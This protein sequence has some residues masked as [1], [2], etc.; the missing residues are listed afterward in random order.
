M[1]KIAGHYFPAHA[2][3][4][5]NGI[6]YDIYSIR[7][8]GQLKPSSQW[9]TF[10][11]PDEKNSVEPWTAT[12]QSNKTFPFFRSP[13]T[14]TG[15]AY[16]DDIYVVSDRAFPDRIQNVK[17]M[18]IRHDI[19]VSTIQWRLDER[20]RSKCEDKT[21]NSTHHELLNLTPGSIGNVV[22]LT[23]ILINSF[24]SLSIYLGDVTQL[25]FCA[26]T[27]HHVKIWHQIAAS[28]ST[29]SLVLEDDAIFVPFFKEK[30]DRFVYTAIR[31]G[32]LKID[33]TTCATNRSNISTNE[34]INQDPAFV[35]GT[36]S[37]L[38]DS[39]FPPNKHDAPP[40]L[41]THKEKFSRCSH[42]YVLNRCSA[43]ALLRQMYSKRIHFHIIDWLQT[44]LGETSPTL[45]PFWLDPGIAHQGSE[46]T[47]LQSISTFS[48]S[49]TQQKE[50]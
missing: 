45:Q 27:M 3:V 43:Q 25:R 9:L 20:N 6:A 16:V 46:A 41:S 44:Y 30:F 21:S 14:K 18:F 48:R 31:T 5:A 35:I 29:L 10:P 33:Q 50:K 12:P 1:G 19:P 13:N 23:D 17:N 2:V 38:R 49:M 36:C 4:Y 39:T 15:L 8:L 26:V 47:D 11:L 22:C 7:E 34:W 28:N 37:G 40:R 32:A 42:A 24:I